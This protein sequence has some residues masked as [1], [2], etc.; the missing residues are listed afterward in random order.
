[1]IRRLALTLC[2]LAATA[3]PALAQDA[4]ELV[5]RLNRLEGQVRQMSGQIEQLQYDNRQLRDQTRKFQ[6][7]VEYRLQ[8]RGG[9]RGASPSATPP[10]PSASPQQPRPNRRSDAFDADATP[11]APGAPRP[12]G[13]TA[14]SEPLAAE[15]APAPR[16]RAE[17]RVSE[18][19]AFSEGGAA[20]PL[21]LR[22]AGRPAPP[23][24]SASG[25]A[26]VSGINPANVQGLNPSA[27]AAGAGTADGG[28]TRAEY[29]A[30][31]ANIAAKNYDAAEAA[32]RRFVAAHPRDRL[33]G[34]ATYWLGESYLQRGKHRE[35]AEQFL[36]VS[37][38]HARSGKAPDALLKLGVSL[39]A[40]GAKDQACAT[41]AEA[42]RKY[43]N[44]G[45]S[46]KQGI[47]REQKKARCA[48]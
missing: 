37:T 29:D 47:E 17:R 21:D 44:A 22:S 8:E 34:D 39:A 30:A 28:G 3:V 26:V 46:L 40:L 41:F 2:A 42:E 20:A 14:A 23:A 38:E 6:E 31:Y 13:A 15:S 4:A 16:L 9:G 7:D 24:P 48:A 5:V 27:A 10:A 43:P 1:M 12:L 36:K 33:A 11:E 32:F 18:D 45:A 35:A 25:P 19:T